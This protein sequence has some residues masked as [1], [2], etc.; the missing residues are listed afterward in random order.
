[1]IYKLVF[2]IYGF[3]KGRMNFKRLAKNVIEKNTALLFMTSHYIAQI[4]AEFM[5]NGGTILSTCYNFSHMVNWCIDKIPQEEEKA[6]QESHT[7]S[8][9]S[10]S[11]RVIHL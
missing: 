7:I 3:M 1:M 9:S 8:S 6:C 11:M 5:K 4:C 10:A 2:K